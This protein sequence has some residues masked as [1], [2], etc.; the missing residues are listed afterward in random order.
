MPIKT[1]INVDDYINRCSSIEELNKII[2]KCNKKIQAIKEDK[3]VE[4]LQKMADL[5][6]ELA[7]VFPYYDSPFYNDQERILEWDE[8]RDEIIASID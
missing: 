6:E 1:N 2:D 7:S 8:V 5:A 4:L 3:R